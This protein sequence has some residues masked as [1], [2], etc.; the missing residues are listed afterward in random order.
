MPLNVQT[1]M[2][3]VVTPNSQTIVTD[4]DNDGFL[5]MIVLDPNV[6]QLSIIHQFSYSEFTLNQISPSVWPASDPANTTP[7]WTD[8]T[9]RW[10]TAWATQQGLVPAP[11]APGGWTVG[12]GDVIVAADLDGDGVDEL[13]IYNLS[14]LFWG[15]LKWNSNANELQAIYSMYVA[16]NNR[17]VPVGQ[18]NWGAAVGDQYIMIPNMHAIIPAIPANVT[19]ILLFNSQSLNMGM[20]WFSASAG[21][22][23]Q[24]YLS[25]SIPGWT[26]AGS[27]EFFV[28]NFVDPARPSI[29]VYDPNDKYTALLQWNGWQFTTLS[30]QSTKAG[31]WGFDSADQHQCA[32]LDGDGMAEILVYNPNTQYLGVLKWE[33]GQLQSLAV[34]NGTIGTAPK[35][36]TI[37]GNEKYYLLNIPGSSAQIYA[38]SPGS[39]TVAVLGYQSGGFVCQWANTSLAPNNGWPVSAADS[40]YVGLPSNPT[41]PKL[42][43][44]S[45]QGPTSNSVYTLGAA[46]W[47]GT[48]VQ[49]VSSATVPVQAWSPAFLASA[50]PTYV[51]NGPPTNFPV[52]QG[53]QLDIYTYISGLFPVPGQQNPSPVIQS[54]RACYT[55][56]NYAGYFQDYGTALQNASGSMSPLPNGWP[57]VN[58]N[59]QQSDWSTVLKTI[60]LECTQVTGVNTIFNNLTAIGGDLY[61]FQQTDLGQVKLYIAELAANGGPSDVDY[62]VGQ[63]G[64]ALIW[65]LAA[66]TS[67]F[68]PPADA[69][70]G[71]ALG[72]LLSCSAS[73]VGGALGYNPSQQNSLEA[74]Q[75]EVEM[76]NTFDQSI[77]AGGLNRSACLQDGIKLKICA[78]LL[79]T[80]WMISSALPASIPPLTA[81][82]RLLMY[83]HLMPFFFNIMYGPMVAPW[84]LKSPAVLYTAPDGTH[85]GMQDSFDSL[86]LSQ[87]TSSNLYSDLFTTIGVSEEDFFVGNGDWSNIKRSYLA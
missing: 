30:G 44:L 36:W 71:T 43:T 76:Q 81:M 57:P 8:N 23:L 19:G 21:Q 47:D 1:L 67:A 75:M 61:D 54:V 46:T 74:D 80:E 79:G 17:V 60:A 37:S 6:K 66:A 5:E 34:Q 14:T 12:L 84:P 29:T 62:W 10:W 16:P 3:S 2:P 50:P 24:P 83:Q 39:S 31:N 18:L 26:L 13:F 63:Y 64:V 4:I 68:F 51:L 40:F 33:N 69:A 53:D 41:A 32:D 58:P 45:N 52:F 7:L 28:D 82:D 70:L 87:F 56:L 38:Y 49:I 55:N 48:N 59:W 86:S 85:Y 25:N 72:I 11:T 20:I 42:F 35:D 65:G 77:V 9:V 22:F 73:V 78:G 15:I 27:N